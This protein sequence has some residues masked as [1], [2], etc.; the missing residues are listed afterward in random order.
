MTIRVLYDRDINRTY[1]KQKKRVLFPTPKKKKK[2]N[3]INKTKQNGRKQNL[4]YFRH[5]YTQDDY[6][7]YSERYFWDEKLTQEDFCLQCD[8]VLPAHS[9]R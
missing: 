8:K 5:N 7:A 6:K 4:F 1:L 3:P 2:K 9:H